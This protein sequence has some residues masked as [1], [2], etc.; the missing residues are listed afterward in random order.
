M[1]HVVLSLRWAASVA[2]A[3]NAEYSLAAVSMAPDAPAEIWAVSQGWG[4]IHSE[5]GGV[6]WAWLCDEGLSG[7]GGSFY[8]VEALGGGKALVAG[9][10]GLFRVDPGCDGVADAAC[11]R[12]ELTGLPD[13]SYAG[14]IRRFGDQFLVSVYGTNDDG[15]DL[16]GAFL[17]TDTA[18]AATS[19]TGPDLY[20]KSF[21]V[22]GAT[23]WATTVTAESLAAGLWRSADGTTWEPVASWP[24]GSP[25]MRVLDARG[26][27]LLV[28]AQT[29]NDLAP[30]GLQR[31]TDGGATW[32]EVVAF[33]YFTDQVPPVVRVGGSGILLLG[34]NTLHVFQSIDDGA[35]WT[36]I[37][38]IHPEV[39]SLRC[40]SDDGGLVCGDHFAD[41]YDL[42]RVVGITFDAFACMDEAALDPALADVCEPYYDDFTD[43][44]ALGGGECEADLTPVES[45]GC[46]GG[47][48]D[49]AGLV[50]VGLG[51][52]GR[53]RRH[54]PSI[55][56]TFPANAP[57]SSL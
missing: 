30:P 42:A 40:V 3:H 32:T 12:T 41:G 10:V 51:A 34:N 35:T 21:T 19:L 48:A 17:C 38:D 36:D 26:D 1:L 47:G 43:K 7:G 50:V 22:D 29:R 25:D 53:R 39:P 46:G 27:R 37:N 55:R 14:L 11:V 44:G 13:S 33:G 31:S 16:N 49:T 2:T 6:S 57:P 15:T 4:V 45:G 52:L 9:T 5:D 28:W 8:D 18:C 56:Y 54:R 20:V 23:V 24:A